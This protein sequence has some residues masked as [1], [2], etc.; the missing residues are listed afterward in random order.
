MTNTPQQKNEPLP[1]AST[2]VEQPAAHVDD[3]TVDHSPLDQ[4]G[5][6]K[7]PITDSL[8]QI[9]DD[10]EEINKQ[11][12]TG[13]EQPTEPQEVLEGEVIEAKVHPRNQE[14]WCPNP[15]GRPEIPIDADFL[16]KC[17][18]IAITQLTQR[19]IALAIGMAESTFYDKMTKFPEI[20]EAIAR[21][22]ARGLAKVANTLHRKAVEGN[23]DACKFILKC[24]GGFIETSQV[25]VQGAIPIFISKDDAEL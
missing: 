13:V 22:K 21:G 12:D 11:H 1:N 18:G 9:Q 2:T 19:D 4:T 7:T 24:H 6:S 5:E 14:G 20:K 16:K 15:D 17:E 25:N 8:K 23:V 3:Q 10:L